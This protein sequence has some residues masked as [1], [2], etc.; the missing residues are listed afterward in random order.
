MA[1]CDA[2]LC[3]CPV[4]KNVSPQG[5][6]CRNSSHSF[7]LV[8]GSSESSPSVDVTTNDSLSSTSCTTGTTSNS[9]NMS[10]LGENSAN[11]ELRSKRTA[12]YRVSCPGENCV[13]MS[14]FS[15]DE[16]DVGAESSEDSLSTSD[17][18]ENS[19]FVG[20]VHKP[21]MAHDG[22]WEAI[23]SVQS[24]EGPLGLH[25]FRL[26]KRLGCGDI[27]SVYLAELKGTKCCFAMKVMDK[28]SLVKRKK[29]LR[30]QTE[31]EILQGLDH[32]FLPSLYTHF[33]TEK[34]TCLV[35]EF[36]PG[37]DLH[38][39]RQKQLRKHFSEPVV[40]FY[41]AEVLLALEYLH[42]M[43]IIYRDLKPENILVR[44]DGH[45]MLSDF[46]LSL[47]C[48]VRPTLVKS[49]SVT[50][51]DHTKRVSAYCV[52]P[53]C[54]AACITP[55]CVAPVCIPPSCLVPKLLTSLSFKKSRKSK[56]DAGGIRS[57]SLP[58]LLVEPT[59]ARSMSFVGTHE[60]LA[61]EIIKGE[62]HGSA[63]DWWTFGILLY[64]LL[65]GK[66]PFKG[67]GNRATL[68]NV[69]GQPLK[70]PDSPIV[71]H[72]AKDLI[73]GLLVKDPEE[74][75]ACRRGAVEIKQ[76]AFFEGVNWALVRSMAPPGI[77]GPFESNLLASRPTS[78]PLSRSATVS[79]VPGRLEESIPPGQYLEFNFF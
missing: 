18:I 78:N 59:G 70:F 5:F 79:H 11:G 31:R 63:V 39:L 6:I 64:E 27:G 4:S 74:R 20:F 19:P 48:V 38:M 52:R 22:K 77:P 68:F 73:E 62:G 75:L 56:Q 50:D 12:G 32:P 45:I 14:N 65:Y 57:C 8:E 9:D 42:M 10:S 17:G 1:S 51:S 15:I 53:I 23:Q 71:S 49:A 30:A 61:P 33:D 76:H 47:Q 60:Y 21:H 34:F 26:L 24:K 69:V 7:I 55:A 41:A 29:L 28:E 40:R 72:A 35:M 2:L 46:D 25:H 3:K 37:G 36:C 44:E 13:H 54:E 43:G 66:T 58:E 67:G 16:H